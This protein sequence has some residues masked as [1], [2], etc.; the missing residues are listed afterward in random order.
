MLQFR[1]GKYDDDD[2]DEADADDG[3][4]YVWQARNFDFRQAR[5][6]QKKKTE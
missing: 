2:D 5:P 6:G 1:Q 3:V 4:G